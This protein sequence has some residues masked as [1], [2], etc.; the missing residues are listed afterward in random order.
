VAFRID[1]IAPISNSERIDVLDVLR[2]FALF[3]VLWANVLWFF[4]GYGDLTP[5]ERSSVSNA[6]IDPVVLKFETF[7]VVNKFITIFSFLFGVGF[8]IQ[9]RRANDQDTFAK[10]LFVR[11]MSWL[12][13][14]GVAHA[15]FIWSGDILHLYA[16]LGILMMSVASSSDRKLIVIGLIAAVLLP[17]VVRTTIS[18]IPYMTDGGVDPNTYF[19]LRWQAASELRAAIVHG[20][21]GDL[22]RAN[23]ADFWAWLS[24]DDAVTTGAA[25]F[26]KFLLGYW[27]GRA[28]IL[29][30]VT[31]RDS[32][33]PQLS[34]ALLLNRRGLLYGG[35]TGVVSQGLIPMLAGD[36]WQITLLRSVLWDMG[37]V[38]LAASYV[39]GIVLLF[40]RP[41]WRKR[42]FYFAPVGR[43]AL[44]N[45]LAQ[46]VICSVLFYGFGLYGRVGPTGSLVVTLGVFT[47][48][49][50]FSIL[51]LKRFRFGPAEWVWR[52]LTYRERQPFS[53]VSAD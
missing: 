14:F 6:L 34:S 13:V 50:I 9:M 39:C 28:G 38:T 47:A 20:S 23:A 37:V 5:A 8:A 11:R 10:R 49:A 45:Y 46:S 36:S 7:F 2:G 18:F 40:R 33:E 12:F 24:T 48:Q 26:G 19:E 31:S 4:S 15:L 30:L 3:G 44:T 22:I 17:S 43:M 32:T 52:S 53:V 1:S 16:V 35:L 21:Y 29:A 41:K 42:L 27:V 51:W 25:S